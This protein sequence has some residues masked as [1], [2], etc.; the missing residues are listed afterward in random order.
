M[1]KFLFGLFA[2]VLLPL[3]S[4]GQI[5]REVSKSV[6][7]YFR[8]G[9]V[10]IDENYMG[11]KA[12]LQQ[13]ADELKAYHADSTAR[14]RRIRIIGSASPEGSTA[15]ND[16][17]S[18][19]RARA[20]AEWLGRSI[21][22]KNLGFDVVRNHIDWDELTSL[23]EA[24]QEVPY[25][26]EVLNVLRTFPERITG[27]NGAVVNE[28][29]NQ[30]VAL[31]NGV[32][33][34]YL[35]SKLF[36]RLRY[37]NARAEFWWESDPRIDITTEKT[38]RFPAE[39][40]NGHV[41]FKKNVQDD[42]VP[43][44][45][46]GAEWI[47]ALTPSVSDVTFAV[48]P[49]MSKEQRTTLIELSSYGRTHKVNVIQEGREP[50]FDITSPSP[51]NFPAE[52]GSSAITFQ[53]NITDKVAPTVKNESEWLTLGAPTADSVVVTAAPNAVETPR[54][55]NV[56]VECY[57]TQY[58]VVVNQAA[59]EPKPEPVVEEKK[60]FYMALKNNMLY[61]LAAIPNIGA[62]FYLGKNFS[63]VANWGYAWWGGTR[64]DIYWRYYGGDLAV[65][66]WF[67]KAS[68]VKPLQGHHV[69]VYG[70]VMTYDFEWGKKGIM[71]GDPGENIFGRSNQS[72]GL[73]YGYSVPVARRLNIDFTLGVGY[74]WGIFHEYM[75]ID[76]HY[77]WQMTKRRRFLGPTKLEISLSW[78]LG[79]GN[80]NDDFK[81]RG[82]KR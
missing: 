20:I 60:P 74:H 67:G 26:D 72:I 69:G 81:K 22:V 57:G 4:V 24:S 25:R 13:F 56:A 15:I 58:E 78:L 48:A 2:L 36:P 19:A 23:V 73:E 49:N 42:V 14:F 65:R 32:P 8:Q 50:K 34:R 63:A 44:A 80:Y 64:K 31:R 40:G 55:T 16:R 76:G 9:S 71:G 10:I 59:A 54:S 82:G 1:K 18:R 27:L 11:N 3:V 46:A 53:H 33:Y 70:Q 17:I 77:V 35:E 6:K 38:L 47:Q 21:A 41:G 45:V 29:Y 62:E 66:W 52:G 43:A 5:E 61:D 51:I 12:T 37:A 7:I 39:G 28:R 79:R 68:K 75:P 30:L